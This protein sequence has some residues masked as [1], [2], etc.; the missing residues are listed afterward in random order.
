[1]DT[2]DDNDG[3][4]NEDEKANG[5]D[6]K[7]TDS[8]GDGTP[9]GDEDSDGDGITDGDESDENSG[10]ITDKD[11]DG[12]ADLM[13]PATLTVDLVD[14]IDKTNVSNA[15]ING[16]STQ[17]P[18]GTVIT[19]TIKDKDGKEVQKTATIKSD[20][21]Y[22]TTADLSELADGPISVEATA[23]DGKVKATDDS[24]NTL[25]TAPAAVDPN[26]GVST[27]P[28]VNE[29]ENIVTTVKLTNNNGVNNLPVL[30]S[31][32][33]AN[34]DDF[35]DTATT[36]SDGV[37]R[38]AD[39]TLN[40]PV[41]VTSFTITTP[42]KADTVTEGAETVKYTVGGVAGNEATIN[43][44]STAPVTPTPTPTPS[45][46][47]PIVTIN[48]GGDG[49][50]TANDMPKGEVNVTVD[51]PKDAGYEAGDT[52]KIVD[53]KGNVLLDRPL[54]QADIDNGSITVPWTP[55]ATDGP[56]TVTATITTKPDN[57]SVSGSD[58]TTIKFADKPV[59]TAS[60]TD[61][62]VTVKPG[63]DNEKVDI[64]FTDENDQPKTVTVTK[65]PTT[66]EWE[67]TN[68]DGTGAT[69]DKDTGVVTIPQDDVKDGSPVTATGTDDVDNT[70]EA[71]PVNAGT[72]STPTP[73][74]NTAD[75]PII[76]PS[77]TDGSVKVTP[78]TDN[79]T[80]E[81]KFIG[82]DDQPKTVTIFKDPTS[83]LWVINDPDNSG[84]TVDHTTGVVTIPENSVKDGSEVNATGTDEQGA[85]ADAD[86]KNAGTD[87]ASTPPTPNT[88]DKPEITAS[89][90]DGSV[91][92]KPGDD[93]EKVD[94]TFTGED[95]QPKTVTVT[96]NPTTG[97]WTITDAGGTGATVDKDTGVVT[98]PQDDVKDGSPVNAKGTDD[99]GAIADATPVNAGTDSTPTPPATN[100]A[101][102]P[103]ITASDT[104]GSVTVKPGD[105][106]EKVDITFTGE[107]EQP[108]TVT[109]T[110]NPT[111]GEWEITDADGTGATV[112]KDTGVVTIPQDAVKDGS[113][114]NAKGTDDQKATADA[115]PV[116]AG[117][118]VPPTVSISVTNPV[119]QEKGNETMDFT[120]TLNKVATTD[121]VVTVVLRQTEDDTVHDASVPSAINQAQPTN[122]D[123]VLSTTDNITLSGNTLTITIPAGQTSATF[124]VNPFTEESINGL[125]DTFGGEPDETVHATIT[126]ATNGYTPA[127]G[128]S[129]AQ[130]TIIDNDPKALNQLTLD[131]SLEVGPTEA[132]M[133]MTNPTN[134]GQ[135]P[136]GVIFNGQAPVFLTNYDDVV[137]LGYYQSG[138][139]SSGAGNISSLLYISNG[140]NGR[141]TDD[142]N[143]RTT[144]DLAQGD[145]VLW[146]KGYQG[147]NASVYLGEGNDIYRLSG[148]LDGNIYGEAGNDEI[149]VGGLVSSAAKIYTGSG[150]DTVTLNSGFDGLIDL[151][152]GVRPDEYLDTYQTGTSLGN[153][154]NTDTASDVNTVKLAGAMTSGQIVGGAGTDILELTGNSNRTISLERLKNMDVIDLTAGNNT[155]TNVT[156]ENLANNNNLHIKGNAGD[157]VNLG[158]QNLL[159]ENTGSFTNT[160]STTEDGVSYNIWTG[161]TSTVYIQDGI[162]V[163]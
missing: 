3:V 51:F 16:T 47:A 110:K 146:V 93:N 151:G 11:G 52:I 4:N 134:A 139:E 18:E 163:I 99:Q 32:D 73:P 91:A 124:K 44:T 30:R 149:T 13:D 14:N 6:P 67:I 78:G 120:V 143:N 156:S 142:N 154:N 71:T 126:A 74:A 122:G 22:E 136:A 41:G 65:N 121:T 140:A 54:T 5:T 127:T 87:G 77:T 105:D 58:D 60:D 158:P 89:T 9:D 104:D 37:T 106:N 131:W 107:D 145:D 34:N 25:N 8:D 94:I 90:T 125:S 128:A 20:G 28:S 42:V 109:V 36:Y 138:T 68:A 62:S 123:Y 70:A 130:G 95:D 118:D 119:V 152:S 55:E 129:I 100:T 116:N 84:A 92:V 97:E 59:I 12:I 80:V 45:L 21:T 81:I 57:T 98:I 112:D 50:I 53:D 85:T 48:D 66:G 24:A 27:T 33:S 23:N 161:G 26:G 38:N 132:I 137:Y 75:K 76:T 19:I 117:T 111:T 147:I 83:N 150:S 56:A 79:E 17:L 159:G 141:L 39:G 31:T 46:K 133:A 10:T 61:G 40:V 153:D 96:K 35:D 7:N 162:T 160:G 29:G 63:D 101:D 114:V 113:P 49:T 115:T 135:F 144:V 69:V 1:M 43:D 103:V 64:T 86:P 88:A 2:D 155:L 108:K 157:R 15:P 72:D 148:G 82:E 102:K